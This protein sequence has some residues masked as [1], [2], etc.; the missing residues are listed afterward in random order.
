MRSF[1]NLK[2]QTKEDPRDQGVTFSG[3]V[4]PE[5]RA[6]GVTFSGEVKPEARA[7]SSTGARAPGVTFAGGINGGPSVTGSVVSSSG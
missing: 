2:E 1:T 6:P 7:P 4:K 3:E 5:A